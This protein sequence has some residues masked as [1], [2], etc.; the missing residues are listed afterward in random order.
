LLINN[1]SRIWSS[2]SFDLA[3]DKS[4]YINGREVITQTALGD[5]ILNSSL[6]TVGILKDLTVD[7]N[8]TV[9]GNLNLNNPLVVNSLDLNE[10]T[11]ASSISIKAAETDVFYANESEIIVGS[12]Q[13]SRRPFKVFG[14]VSIGITNPD[15]SVS[16]AVN[17]DVSF[18]NKRFMNGVGIPVTGSYV[19]G[20]IIWSE[21]PVEDGYVGWVCIRSGA[22][23]EWRPFG[24]LGA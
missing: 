15:P 8:I 2:E 7:G 23:G 24:A 3:A 11:S 17:G 10:L 16:L 5:T 14:S 4:Y 19:K 18:N 13:Q 6:E 22:P 9:N 21:N 1:P 20:D 12:K